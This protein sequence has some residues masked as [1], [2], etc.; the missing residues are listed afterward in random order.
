MRRLKKGNKADHSEKDVWAR[1]EKS[2]LTNEEQS[3]Q[4][5][6]DIQ[7]LNRLSKGN[8]LD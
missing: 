2:Q 3:L 7:D 5:M 4:K 6:L 8:E 1:T